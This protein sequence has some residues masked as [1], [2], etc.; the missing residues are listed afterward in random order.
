MEKEN[1]RAIK[2]KSITQILFPPKAQLES[3]YTYIKDKPYLIPA[4]WIHR[5]I[6]NIRKVREKTSEIK[7]VVSMNDEDI[8]ELNVLYK[9]IGL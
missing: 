1:S 4:A 9:N 7:E 6:S 8:R 2:I 3:K 5:I